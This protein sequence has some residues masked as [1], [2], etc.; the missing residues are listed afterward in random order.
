MEILCFF[1]GTA[2]FYCKSYY[3][4]CFLF[5]M[6]FFRLQIK[7]VIWFVSAILLALLHQWVI[8]DLGMPQVRTIPYA[9]IRGF[10]ATIPTQSSSKTQFQFSIT[11]LNNKPVKARVLLSCYVNCPALHVGQAWQLQAK[12]RKP[13]N[14]ANPGGFDYE[15]FLSA[16]HVT[17]VGSVRAGTFKTLATKTPAYFLVKLREHLGLILSNILPDPEILGIFQALTL[18]LTHNIAPSQWD[19]FRRT[20][21]THLIDISGEHIALVSGL[22]YALFHWIWK[23]T[24]FLCLVLPAPQVASF[25]AIVCAF[26]YALIAGFSVP[27]QRS[28]FAC[29]FLLLGNFISWRCSIWQAWRYALLAVLLFEPHAVLMLGFYFSFI[30]VAILILINQRVT[31]GRVGKMLIMQLACLFGLLPLT[32]YWFSY[33]SLNGFIANIFAIPLFGFVIVPLALLITFCSPFVTLSW[34]V[35]VLKWSISLFLV[36]LHWIDITARFNLNFTFNNVLSPLLMMLGMGV[37]VFFP[38]LRVLPFAYVLLIAS[39]LQR[40]EV[41]RFGSAVIDLLDVG[42]G[43]AVVVR[44]AHHVLIY[45]AGM[46][47]YHGSDMGK[48]AIIPYLNNKGIHQLDKV[49]ISHPDLDHRGGLVSLEKNYKIGELIVDT[50]LF[51]KRGVSCHQYPAWQWDGVDFR[52]F[53]ASNALKGTNNHSCVLQVANNNGQVLLS[54]D[55]EGLAEHDLIRRYGKKL[56]SSVLLVPHHASNSSSTSLFLETVAPHYAIVSYGFDNRYHFPHAR[57][58]QTYA[59]YKIPVYNTVDCGMITIK[60][61]SGAVMPH[62]YRVT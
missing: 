62:C 46:K 57:V 7:W 21:T 25:G 50:P 3:P 31:C 20:G 11:A 45:D 24:G 18:G 47:F 43:L 28:L 22:A 6:C 8:A 2:F 38:V 14:L 61:Q 37:V 29:G 10:V 1:A 59:L 15:S 54:G 58:M 56:A 36:F 35:V 5:L 39:V 48:I 49:I 55:I 51:Y 26:L 13:Y 23:R 12:L 27:T 52:F 4:L 44:T 42:Q 17:W 53:S 30:A 33:G 60:L 40:H 41:V 32:L 34:G 9:R 19:L 16:R